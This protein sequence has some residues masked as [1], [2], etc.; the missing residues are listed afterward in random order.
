MD[1]LKKFSNNNILYLLLSLL[2]TGCIEENTAPEAEN[3]SA[4]LTQGESILIKVLD[5][6][7]DANSDPLEVTNLSLPEKGRVTLQADG[8]VLYQHDGSETAYDQFTYTAFDGAVDSAPA[9]VTLTI[10]SNEDSPDENSEVPPTPAA[11]NQ[12]PIA[13]DD[14]FEVDSGVQISLNLL[15]NDQDPDG[16]PLQIAHLTDPQYG[17]LQ[18]SVDG[19][20]VTY[21]H[22]GSDAEQ[23]QFSYTLSD[24]SNQSQPAQVTIRVNTSNQAPQFTQSGQSRS[25]AIDELYTLVFQAMDPDG[26]D[27]TYRVT[28]LPYWLVYTAETRTISGS[29]SWEELGNRYQIIISASDGINVTDNQFTLNIEQTQSVTDEMAHRLLLQCTFGPVQSEIERV[30]SLG[31]SG[32]IDHQ[33]S[34]NSAYTSPTDG[35]KTNLERTQE[36]ALQAEPGVDWYESNQIFNQQPHSS[37]V[38]DYQMAAWWESALGATAPN[39][40]Q[41]GTDQLRQRIAYALSQLLVVSTSSPAM[42]SRGESLAVYYDLLAKYAFGNYR[43]L[44]KAISISPAM[45][46][47]LSHQGNRKADPDTGSRPDENFAR[48]IIQLFTIGLYELNLDGSPNRDGNHTT[49]PDQGSHTVATYTQ[50]DIEELAKVM[51]GW[52]LAD[53]NKF[54]QLHS[55]SGNYTVPMVFNPSMHEDE[56]AEG[57][58]GRITL[59]GQT[60]SLNA[61]SDQSGLDSALDRLFAHPNVAPYVSKHLIQRL[62]T[63]NPSANYV[64][65]IAHIFNDNGQGVKGDLKAVV[66]GI[67][68]DPEARD[69]S[70]QSNPAYGKAKEPLL[71]ITQLLRAAHVAPLNGWSSK[72]NVAMSHVYWYRE[73]EKQINQAALRAPSVFNFYSPGHVPSDPY[74]TSHQLVGPEFQIQ[75]SQMLV[76]YNNLVVYLISNLEKNRIINNSGK[77]LNEFASSRKHYSLSLLT[78]FDIEL[79]LLEQAL[80]ND[81]NGDFSSLNDDTTDINGDTPKSRGI[82]ALIDHLDLQLLGR[83]MSDEYRDALKHYLMTSSYTNS[84]N[85]VESARRIVQEAYTFIT[86]SSAYMIQK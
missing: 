70:Y 64:A 58:D 7:S 66:R 42:I 86:T 2:L 28:G 52:D 59:M 17:S 25:I 32:W 83:K 38:K 3:D 71:A 9:T 33:L 12:R 39:R 15:Q 53:N 84:G 74:F 10:Q 23:D 77:S 8:S 67:L 76:D 34:M 6:D 24:G 14:Q 27:L 57:G 82:D 49:Y 69:E 55:S 48:E 51:T 75:T 11:V 56:A 54:G 73:P 31:I 47:Y 85:N 21:R 4:T 79:R 50:S 41:I 46:V 30:K 43:Q 18:L 20:S 45:G 78:S 60:L 1:A 19:T 65:R 61:G 68:L 37:S 5:N 44:L 81:S 63:S 22:N 62:V 40:Q 35:W 80:E 36:I 72:Q 26:D 29:P 13:A 16:D